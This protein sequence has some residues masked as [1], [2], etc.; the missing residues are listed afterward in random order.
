MKLSSDEIEMVGCI[1]DELQ[2]YGYVTKKAKLEILSTVVYAL[3]NGFPEI[4]KE[5]NKED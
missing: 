3:V 1:L 2:D 5:A 4:V